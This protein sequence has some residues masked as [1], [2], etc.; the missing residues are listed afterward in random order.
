[1]AANTIT[2]SPDLT[3]RA[4]FATLTTQ[5]QKTAVGIGVP[6]EHRFP[7]AVAFSAAFA[8][9][10][11]QPEPMAGAR[12]AVPGRAAT[13]GGNANFARSRP[14]RLASVWSV[15][16]DTGDQ[17]MTHHEIT[18]LNLSVT[19]VVA[20]PVP[21]LFAEWQRLR[22]DWHHN[23]HDD[24]GEET[25]RGKALWAKAYALEKQM[26]TTQP[27]THEGAKALIDWV[28]SDSENADFYEGQREA[29]QMASEALG[30]PPTDT[31]ILRLFR[32]IEAISK[33]AKNHKTDLKGEA[34]DTELERLF[35]A[36]RDRLSAAMMAL[37]CT[38]AA[39][40]AAKAV[41]NTNKGD[42]VDAWDDSPL[43]AEARA[44][45]GGLD[46]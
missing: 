22:A 21:A 28:L 36:P 41:V 29:L 20:D 33:A 32:E 42:F 15:H 23:G 44:L 9:S 25:P 3:R 38:C 26:A 31:P 19:D 13:C 5:S 2:T 43:W 39:D 1:M 7:E 6:H 34:Q 24:T 27:T 18:A 46:A 17:S 10:G 45:I 30:I 35:Y 11:I 12:E 16:S 37:P 14:P 40:F 8:V 4:S